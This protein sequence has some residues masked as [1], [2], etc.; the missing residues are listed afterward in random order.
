MELARA[1]GKPDYHHNR[2]AKSSRQAVALGRVVEKPD[3]HHENCAQSSRQVV[4]LGVVVV[5][6]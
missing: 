3:C 2:C 5:E 1:V 4:G 6:Q